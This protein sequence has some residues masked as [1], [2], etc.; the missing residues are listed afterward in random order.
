MD[1]KLKKLKN[2]LEVLSVPMPSIES[3]TLAVW[4]R[5]GS[6]AESDRISGISHFLEHMAFKGGR[7]FPSAKIVSETAE[8]DADN[9]TNFDYGLVF[10]ASMEFGMGM[11]KLIFDA[12]YSMGLANILDDHEEDQYLKNRAFVLMVGLKF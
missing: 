5:T 10:G 6:R 12:R 4:V 11:M 7:K 3:A 9:I 1:C 8:V 2:G